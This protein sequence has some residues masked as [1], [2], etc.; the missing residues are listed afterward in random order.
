MAQR[1]KNS[2]KKLVLTA[3]LGAISGVL[4]VLEFPLPFI[5]PFIKMDFSELP[6]ILGGFIMGPVNGAFV[7]LI[8]IL[9]NFVLNGTTTF[10]IGELAN[11]LYSIGYM[12]PAVIVYHKLKTK[13][14][15]VIS[16][17]IGTVITSILAVIINTT[18]TFPVY[19]KLMGFDI[20]AIVAMSAQTN[21]F[22]KDLFT[23]MLC[24]ILPFNLFK[25]GVTSI[26]TFLLYKKL[27]VAIKD[28]Y[29]DD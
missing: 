15:A 25:Y 24:S 27:S 3:V 8:K 10:G 12:L 23:L 29:M 16:L 22:V 20:P 4:M 14:G 13:K 5:P 9:I 6:V 19:G 18:V 1:N 21:P 28:H 17:V 7:S 2:T 11:F 26:L